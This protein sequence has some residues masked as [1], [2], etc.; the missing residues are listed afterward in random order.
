MNNL[1][2]Y[3]SLWPINNH[4][5][6]PTIDFLN[7]SL[8]DINSI[9]NSYYFEKNKT[10]NFNNYNLYYILEYQII[11][12]IFQFSQEA[13]LSKYTPHAVIYFIEK[14]VNIP[15]E[16]E[17]DSFLIKDNTYKNNKTSLNKLKIKN[18]SQL[19]EQNFELC[20]LTVIFICSKIYDVDP[21][22]L[23]TLHL[24]S[25]NSYSNDDIKKTEIIILKTIDYKS[26]NRD[27][28]L[29][30]KVGVLCENLK[31]IIE[32]NIFEYFVDISY[33]ITDLVISNPGVRYY[34]INYQLV[35]ACAVVNTSFIIITK[36]TGVTPLVIRLSLLCKISTDEIIIK[37]E[38][39]LKV[40]LGK[41]IFKKFSF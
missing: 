29:I 11:E 35:I 6:I 1:F 5:N 37:S 15:N 10:N 41:D 25:S 7:F 32:D 24:I 21:I 4:Y 3:S 22:K 34:D 20:L 2:K 33:D 17:Y 38:K 26:I 31:P 30:D 16:L 27:Y 39:I 13:N 12:Y 36:T 23:N 19:L 28:M 8:N 40:V 14:L 9:N 18:I